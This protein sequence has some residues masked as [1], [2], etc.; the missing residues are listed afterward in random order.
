MKVRIE[1]QR[2]KGHQNCVRVAPQLFVFGEDGFARIR[3]NGEVP[4]AL[5]E[6][7]L[8]AWDNCPEFAI[9][10]EEPETHAGSTTAA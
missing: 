8:L 9:E 3:G 4:Q 5:R 10:I 7:A 1:S 2:C 6:Q